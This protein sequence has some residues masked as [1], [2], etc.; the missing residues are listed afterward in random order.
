MFLCV[1]I[2]L[3][4]QHLLKSL[5]F[6]Y[7]LTLVPLSKISCLYTCESLSG[8]CSVLSNYLS[9]FMIII[10]CFDYCKFVPNLDVSSPIIFFLFPSYFGESFAFPYQF[11]ISLLISKIK[12]WW[13]SDW[14]SVESIN[15][16]GKNWYLNNI[17]FF[18]PWAQ[19]ISP[20]IKSLIT[21]NN[22]L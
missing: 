9:V 15:Q 14:D 12:A 3:F 11:K 1:D 10:H 5:S 16:Y 21:L 13:D 17:E 18:D 6:F 8:L 7:Q 19:Y 2:L 4:Q 22:A 20:F